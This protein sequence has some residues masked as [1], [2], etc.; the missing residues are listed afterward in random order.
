ML[1]LAD[2]EVPRHGTPY[3]NIAFIVMNVMVFFYTVTLS[4][5]GE[6]V[7]FLRWGLLPAELTQGISAGVERLSDGSTVDLTSP[8]PDWATLVTSMFIHGGFMHIGGNMLFLWVFGDNIEDRL[9]HVGYALF[10][11]AA[12]LVAGATHILFSWD[13]VVP[14][15]GAS[16]AVAGVLGAYLMYYPFHRVHT[17]IFLGFFITVMEIPAVLLHGVWAFLQ[18]LNGVLTVGATGGGVAY[19]A[20]IGGFAAGMGFVAAS[21][22][23]RGQRVWNPDHGFG[24]HRY[25]R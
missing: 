11:L 4:G 17:L 21:R 12:G 19:W 20:H 18:L 25:Y 13:S 14:T 16:G 6:Q 22:L 5:L 9:G 8:V 7:F 24:F 23:A 3:V 15:V 1:P 2:R 10:Y